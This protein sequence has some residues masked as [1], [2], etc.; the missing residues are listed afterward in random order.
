MFGF[1]RVAEL[2]GRGAS[3]EEL[4][5]LCLT[6]L[7]AF[8]GADAEQEDDITLVSLQRSMSAV[9]AGGDT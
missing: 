9:Y 1:P 5:D 3:G 4:I 8:T 6:E 7:S 2:T